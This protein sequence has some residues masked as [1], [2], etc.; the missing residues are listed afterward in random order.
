MELQNSGILNGQGSRKYILD[1][2]QKL[3]YQVYRKEED[4]IFENVQSPTVRPPMP[5]NKKIDDPVEASPLQ[6]DTSIHND[7]GKKSIG[8]QAQSRLSKSVVS[9]KLLSQN[10]PPNKSGNEDQNSNL[11]MVWKTSCFLIFTIMKKFITNLKLL[12]I[13]LKFKGL[14]KK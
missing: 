13:R 6:S 2:N 7:I 3:I 11:R 14:T 12:S 5:S 10:P 4:D 8:S 1:S 9:K